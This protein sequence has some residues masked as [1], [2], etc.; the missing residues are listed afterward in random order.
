MNLADS[1][2]FIQPVRSLV[3]SFASSF[4]ELSNIPYQLYAYVEL[5]LLQRRP[6]GNFLIIFLQTPFETLERSLLGFQR[7]PLVV[8]SGPSQPPVLVASSEALGEL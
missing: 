8:I 6:L 7:I 3:D 5:P 2:L 4:K 1:G